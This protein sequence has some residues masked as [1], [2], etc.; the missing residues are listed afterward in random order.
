MR[1]PREDDYRNKALNAKLE[2]NTRESKAGG[3]V[4]DF[5]VKERKAKEQ[6]HKRRG[7]CCMNACFSLA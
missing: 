1:R 4:S 5:Q 2:S 7:K 3:K 6:V